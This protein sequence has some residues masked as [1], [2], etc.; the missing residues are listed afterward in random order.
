MNRN[1]APEDDFLPY[2]EFGMVTAI[3]TTPMP[4]T[5]KDIVQHLISEVEKTSQQS[6]SELYFECKEA[7][8]QPG[9]YPKPLRLKIDKIHK[10]IF[11]SSV[12]DGLPHEIKRNVRDR[13]WDFIGI[14]DEKSEISFWD[15]LFG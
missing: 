14:D 11:E 9:R 10:A 5:V 4:L 8:K 15:T 6:F 13:I 2:P 7:N 1:H 12:C 3:E